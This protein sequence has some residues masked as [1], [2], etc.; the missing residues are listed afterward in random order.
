MMGGLWPLLH[1]SS[2]E[3]VTGAKVDDFLVR[4][5]AGILVWTGGLLL[6]RP[7]QREDGVGL[8][9]AALGISLVLGLVALIGSISGTLRWVYFIDGGMHLLFATCWCI[10]LLSH[11][12]YGTSRT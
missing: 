9:L 12:R 7:R 2:F 5:V 4:S 10:L 11:E 8:P 3:A 1:L 6:L